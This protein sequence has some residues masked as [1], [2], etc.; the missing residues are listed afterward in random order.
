MSE[1]LAELPVDHLAEFD[2]FIRDM[3]RQYSTEQERLRR[4]VIFAE[5]QRRLAALQ[6]RAR[7]TIFGVTRF[8]DLEDY[9][10]QQVC[11]QAL[12]V[13]QIGACSSSSHIHTSNRRL[14]NATPSKWTQHLHGRLVDD[15][16]LL[17]G[18]S[19]VQ[20]LVSRIKEHVEV[21]GHLLVSLD[22]YQNNLMLVFSDC[23]RRV[24]QHHQWW[25]PSSTL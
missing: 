21:V 19:M 13:D 8:A 6:K 24:T 4:F 16:S 15:Q 20:L 7:N 12:N 23:R 14:H 9:E 18:V 2:D 1:L 11:R 22:V 5:N 17:I 25:R 3:K 10:L